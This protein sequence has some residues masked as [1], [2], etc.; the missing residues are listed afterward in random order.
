MH[1][2]YPAP[3][4]RLWRSPAF[5]IPLTIGVVLVLGVAAAFVL[6]KVRGLNT[7]PQAVPADT[8]QPTGNAKSLPAG[9]T[10][11]SGAWTGGTIATARIDAFGAWR[12]Q[13]AD[14]VTTY[15]AYD[16]WDQLKTSDWDVSTLDGFAGRLVYGLPLLPKDNSSTLADVAAG[17]HDDVFAAVAQTLNAHNRGNSYVRIGLEANG[18]WFPWGATVQTASDFKAAYRHVESVM[19][20][21]SP[22][23]QFVFDL[24]CAHPLQG[25]DDRLAALT[26]LYP[27]DD[28]VNVIG[29]DHYDSYTVQDH[30]AASWQKVLHPSD[31]AG[32]GDV[33]DF[34]RQH[35]KKLAVPEW[36]LTSTANSGAGDNPYFIYSMYQ[37]FQQN[38]DILAFENY[39]N[40]PDSSLG[41][42]IWDTDQNPK[43]SA[44]YKK[45]WGS[46]PTL[47]AQPQ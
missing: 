47:T 14:T 18:T 27:G 40:E 34:A 38:K 20:A 21:I 39:F 15:P 23:L 32:L 13:P 33:A 31:A 5:L 17:Q 43:A 30:N 11:L 9:R 37:F 42:S 41:S 6:L 35:G 36:G 12:G 25:S 3:R 45:L 19:K 26:S 2:G 16:T 1:S 8:P 44:E 24:T 10:W 4:R 7:A 28:V 46:A 22:N 29:C